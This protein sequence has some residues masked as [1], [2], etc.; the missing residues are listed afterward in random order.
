MYL[1]N[2]VNVVCS[3]TSTDPDAP[4]DSI[5]SYS[6]N[7]GDQSS[8]ANTST[9]THNFSKGG[10]K[11][12]SLTVTDSF[13]GTNT[14][15]KSIAVR[16]NFPPVASLSC[17]TN[18]LLAACNALASYDPEGQ[19]ITFKFE[20]SDS[21]VETN[22]NG[23]S[24]HAYPLAGLYTVK[25]TVTDSLG[26]STLATTQV[27]AVKPPNQ[28]PTI[29]LNCNSSRPNYLVCNGLG[30][31]DSDGSIVS[32]QYSFDD[33]SSET[34][35]D[36][37]SIAHQFSQSGVHSVVLTTIDNDGGVSTLTKTFSV[38]KNIDP[39]ANFSCTDTAVRTIRCTSTSS[40]SDGVIANTTWTLDDGSSFSGVNFEHAF[41]NDL[42]HV[43]NLKVIDDLGAT[44]FIEKNISVKSNSA[45]VAA[46]T[47]TKTG[48]LQIHC[49][50]NS[51][52]AE[53]TLTNFN[54]TLD[55]GTVYTTKDFD[56]TFNKRAQ[57][58]AISSH[59][60]TLL[61]T[62]S[63]GLT[64]TLS[65]SVDVTLE[66]LTSLPRGYFKVYME[67]TNVNLHST[68]I[69]TQ[70]DIKR[71]YYTVYGT[72]STPLQT[73]EI[74]E[75]YAN[76]INKI[77]LGAMGQY[78]IVMTAID[79]RDQVFTT[80][81]SFNLTEDTFS[82][83]PFVDVRSSQ[84]AT[85]TIY[86]S[87][88]PSFD[89]DDY[90]FISDFT[91]DMG[92][93]VQKQIVDDTFLTYTYAQ[94]GTYK[95]TITA[96]TIH[97]TE[98]T[99]TRSITVT[100]ADVPLQKPDPTFVYEIYSYA[101]NVSFYNEKSGTPNGEIS[102][103]VW[104]FGDNSTATG[105]TQAHFYAPGSYIVS[106]TVTDTA[107]MK[108]T[109]TQ[110]IT[111][112]AE[113][114]DVIAHL[115]CALAAPF[116]DVDQM[117]EVVALDKLKD[118]STVRV[119]WGN[120]TTS[121]LTTPYDAVQGLYYP[122][123]K[124]T[125]AGTYAVKLIVTTNRGVVA[126]TTRSITL[127]S[128]PP[129]AT[130]QCF[131]NNL[132]A[133]CNALASYDP[134]G[135][136]LTYKFN[137]QD[138]FVETNATGVSS[139]AYQAAGLYN[140]S[141]TV[142][143][144]TGLSSIATTSVQMVV[145]QNI[146]PVAQ[147]NC[148][149]NRPNTI[150]CN[151]GPSY[152]PDGFITSAKY[153]FDD[154]IVISY[155]KDFFF[156]H[157]FLNGGNHS[158]KLSV[159]DNSGGQTTI[160]KEFDII[161]NQFP[162]INLACISNT[163]YLVECFTDSHDNDGN[164]VSVRWFANDIELSVIGSSLTK[165]F[166]NLQNVII[167]VIVSDDLNGSSEASFNVIV[168]QNTAPIA[169]INC[170]Q[171]NNKINCN[172]LGSFDPDGGIQNIAWD[173]G[174]GTNS[175]GEFANHE[176]N[177]L[178]QHLITLTVTDNDFKVSSVN[179]TVNINNLLPTVIGDC[180]I[181]GLNLVCEDKG[182]F[183]QDGTIANYRWK[184][185]D[186]PDQIGR[187]INYTLSKAGNKDIYLELTDN[188]GGKSNKLIKNVQ[189]EENLL[190]A[191]ILCL[192]IRNSK[193]NCEVPNYDPNALQDLTYS[194]TLNGVVLKGAKQVFSFEED[195]QYEISLKVTDLNG[196]EAQDV[197]EFDMHPSVD[198]NVSA[199]ALELLPAEDNSIFY[200]LQA[201]LK[202]KVNDALFD[203][204]SDEN[205]IILNGTT[206]DSDIITYDENLKILTLNLNSVDGKNELNLELKDT[207]G[208][209]I[210]QSFV[211]YSGSKQVSL[212]L[213]K[214]NNSSTNLNPFKIE[215]FP[216]DNPNYKIAFNSME[217]SVVIN[218]VPSV[219]FLICASTSSFYGQEM[220]F[221]TKS[222]SVLN[223]HDFDADVDSSNLDFSAGTNGWL[224]KNSE[225]SMIDNKLNLA[226][227][228]DGVATLR[229]TMHSNDIET[230][231]LT[232]SYNIYSPNSDDYYV[233][234]MRNKNTGEVVR[235]FSS[236]AV[237]S[238]L[239]EEEGKKIV[240]ENS[241]A[242][243]SMADIVEV[244]LQL[245]TKYVSSEVVQQKR[246]S[247]ISEF[248][249]ASAMAGVREWITSDIKSI[250]ENKRFAITKAGLYDP[251]SLAFQVD[252]EA[253]NFY[254][255]KNT[256]NSLKFLSIGKY[257]DYL[258]SKT[259]E[260][261]TLVKTVGDTST[262]KSAELKVFLNSDQLI[263]TT[264]ALPFPGGQLTKITGTEGM[265][266]FRFIINS[267]ESVSLNTILDASYLT[268]KLYITL[269]DG[270]IITQNISHGNEPIRPMI[271]LS[272]YVDNFTSIDGTNAKRFSGRDNWLGGDDWI[273][274]RYYKYFTQDLIPINND[275]FLKLK[276]NDFSKMN[277]G[278]HPDHASHSDGNIFDGRIPGYESG[279]TTMITEEKTAENILKYLN[280]PNVLQKTVKVFTTYSS[281]P[282][283][284]SPFFQKLASTC[285]ADG[286]MGD[287]VVRPEKN[288]TDHFHGEFNINR[289]PHNQGTFTNNITPTRGAKYG[290]LKFRL[291]PLALSDIDD[292]SLQQYPF[293]SSS[294][295]RV[296]VQTQVATL[297]YPQI[298]TWVQLE[299][300][301]D[302]DDEAISDEF[303]F[304][305]DGK[306]KLPIDGTN[307][308]LRVKVIYAANN[309]PCF[310][311]PEVWANIGPRLK[312]TSEVQTSQTRGVVKIHY[313][314]KTFPQNTILLKVEDTYENP[315]IK[316][317]FE[318]STGYAYSSG[319]TFNYP[320]P[321]AGEYNFYVS[322]FRNNFV[323]S[324]SG[325]ITVK[326]FP[327]KVL[328]FSVDCSTGIVTT[329]VDDDSLSGS[330]LI[331]SC[332][333]DNGSECENVR[334]NWNQPTK[335]P[336]TI[337][338]GNYYSRNLGRVGQVDVSYSD[339]EF[340]VGPISSS[341]NSCL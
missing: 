20:Y 279:N 65:K 30:S 43:I 147:L 214:E 191:K 170:F 171:D 180:S 254:E 336:F 16:D 267:N 135:G 39:I 85:R 190:A 265:K 234:T 89:Y 341:V 95:L 225:Y 186:E 98:T 302:D 199:G 203:E 319:A 28:L 49:T 150:A 167:K 105:E 136:P 285:L 208:K 228:P 311:I 242:V 271:S 107:G 185:T 276:F 14:V 129:V 321:Y 71:A 25:L 52:D 292:A 162:V 101:Q 305:E 257:P 227:G 8:L 100:D 106:L 5:Q 120:N 53:E 79:M 87:L 27:Q 213:E 75:F 163:K 306:Y 121:T 184:I 169:S 139:H 32:Y 132:L 91:I 223:L 144:N 195:G 288:H 11:N 275:S 299:N 253:F 187:V 212:N 110:K 61:A 86:L 237:V 298:G 113:G 330:V 1:F 205:E 128:R 196:N 81:R 102:S 146:L 142:S 158:I 220:L 308:T 55:D 92:D 112:L 222:S 42:A 327:P 250:Q 119:M 118:I 46:F 248:L 296:F 322:G 69:K 138:G 97:G 337:T 307:Q 114:T 274:T 251:I 168:K 126:T 249:L 34:R 133:N 172:S 9:V 166:E 211:F 334:A 215:L 111:I 156:E 310:E 3:S 122:T 83:A 304:Y 244:E 247:K 70:F 232:L 315:L 40:D 50:N 127:T 246:N 157:K 47:C 141:V 41:S 312:I 22:T 194:W 78:K 209:I 68:I 175:N 181:N 134:K 137:Y 124:Y 4:N 233:L 115:D 116:V 303:V 173:F 99:I 287:H 289:L 280:S 201:V 291:T 192:K 82:L 273:D 109:Q 125:A 189:A 179:F 178:G 262:I 151:A 54:W 277:G 64:S 57:D 204:L 200:P 80:A 183:D 301:H 238:N 258:S 176:Y 340:N 6:W 63:Q 260:I 229:K 210:A 29:K 188:L 60:V 73:V 239:G 15:T 31:T 317:T 45:P 160:L 36:E 33:G 154:G 286:R 235:E 12:I 255:K 140:V 197:A 59:T 130:L 325:T 165:T 159:I 313:D 143:D 281:D 93:G 37:N 268:L 108:A 240:F 164:I 96:R 35:A 328:S 243:T 149:S 152:D 174:D 331:T 19:A 24:T 51:T 216:G 198:K 314:T 338:G 219:N 269:S 13:G 202:F 103:Y 329:T 320:I 72:S 264:N 324:S 123:K 84:S 278:T 193:L 74:T 283:K 282:S 332:P 217:N 295:Y 48:V 259:N 224:I 339:S 221:S 256:D 290:V 90:F 218:N 23:I 226:P 131:T 62:D 17:S 206:I 245:Y 294:S 155:D 145:P 333:Y 335:I 77:N 148:I 207:L 76:T 293:I 56:H 236:T 230:K 2:N 326:N 94:A 117:C 104:D 323:D 284:I 7:F 26:A 318:W 270:Q 241:I 177:E 18:S 182:S 58:V 263:I 38:L 88:N 252:A 153:E 266:G 316:T 297:S 44:A 272:S 161:Q 309:K 261:Y 231:V 66:A 10:N 21:F 67:G 300:S